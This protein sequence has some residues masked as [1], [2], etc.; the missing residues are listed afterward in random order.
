[1][2]KMRRWGRPLATNFVTSWAWTLL[3]SLSTTSS[4][5]SR[6]R[7]DRLWRMRRASSSL[8]TLAIDKIESVSLGHLLNVATGRTRGKAT[9]NRFESDVTW[10]QLIKFKFS[11]K[12]GKSAIRPEQ[13]R[14]FQI[15]SKVQ[16]TIKIKEEFKPRKASLDNLPHSTTKKTSQAYFTRAANWSKITVPNRLLMTHLVY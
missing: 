2:A 4:M 11:L 3:Q 1:M 5:C 6:S 9:K 14:S 7:M 10:F 15:R 13:R 12:C 8:S 16:A